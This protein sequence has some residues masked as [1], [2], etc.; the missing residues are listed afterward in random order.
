M[1]FGL[2][3]A[4]LRV[5]EAMKG[6]VQEF[7]M[8]PARFDVMFVL[9]RHGGA[10]CQ[11]DLWKEL[12]VSR[13][14]ICKMVK[15]MEEKGLVWRRPDRDNPRLRDVIMTEFGLDCFLEAANRFLHGDE[16]RKLFDGIHEQGRAF[17]ADAAEIAKYIA[18]MFWD[19]AEH[20][21]DVDEPDEAAMARDERL[22]AEMVSHVERLE[23]HRPPPDGQPRH[24]PTFE[25]VLAGSSP[26]T[27]EAAR[28]LDAI[29]KATSIYAID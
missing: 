11:S 20:D 19:T 18:H 17:V 15:G 25:E 23:T 16:L 22:D 5:V 10:A 7:H 2:K 28:A 6:L 12:G 3:R 1:S 4:H 9:R 8:T 13:G 29:W 27:L 21:Y 26:E 14:T 24:K